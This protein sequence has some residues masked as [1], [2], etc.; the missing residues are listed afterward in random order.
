P[1]P[2]VGDPATGDTT[3]VNL[4]SSTDRSYAVA[5]QRTNL[6]KR[7]IDRTGPFV[8]LQ[9]LEQ[10]H[11]GGKTTRILLSGSSGLAENRTMPPFADGSN[12]DLL[13]GSPAW[14]SEQDSLISIGPK[15]AGAGPLTLS[16]RDVRVNEAL[17]LGVMPLLVI[18]IG[19]L[20]F[21][22]RRRHSGV[23]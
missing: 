7:A 12:R 13:L 8:L 4:A 23:S 11:P 21:V 3:A 16:D 14:L 20:V 19:A 22:R 9:A 15:P 1:T 2:P 6:D 18:A 5:Q 10:K 17:A